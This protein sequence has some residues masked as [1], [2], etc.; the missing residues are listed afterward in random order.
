MIIVKNDNKIALVNDKNQEVA[1]VSFRFKD[2][3]TLVIEHTVVDENLQGQGIASK[4]LQI[5]VEEYENKG[6]KIIPECSYAQKWFSKHTE[7]KSLLK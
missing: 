6:L 2:E 5:F 3:K 7:Y 4:L 1:F